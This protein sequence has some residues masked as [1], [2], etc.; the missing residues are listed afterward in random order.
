VAEL[1]L[2]VHLFQV[3]LLTDEVLI[4]ELGV[5]QALKGTVHIAR[6]MLNMIHLL[7]PRLYRPLVLGD[8]SGVPLVLCFF[9]AA[10]KLSVGHW[11]LV[12]AYS[13]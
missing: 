9:V 4:E 7:F 3:S 8:E 6:Y 13:A 10:R 2:Q 1:A 5:G 11:L 12:F